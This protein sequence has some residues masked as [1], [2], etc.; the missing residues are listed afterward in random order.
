MPDA[1]ISASLSASNTRKLS[2]FFFFFFLSKAFVWFVTRLLFFQIEIT[3]FLPEKISIKFQQKNSTAAVA[4]GTVFFSSMIRSVIRSGF[5]RRR[6][7]VYFAYNSRLKILPFAVWV[8]NPNH[9]NEHSMKTK[10]LR[11]NKHKYITI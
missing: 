11:M 1:S 5:R 2:S 10:I 9:C 4:R 3:N 6:S 7:F 8:L